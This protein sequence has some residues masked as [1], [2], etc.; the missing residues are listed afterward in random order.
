MS[1]LG[2]KQTSADV[3]VMSA[4]SQKPTLIEQVGMSAVPEA[5]ILRSGTI[6]GYLALGCIL[7]SDLKS[8]RNRVPHH[9]GA[10]EP[11]LWVGQDVQAA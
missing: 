8:S 2:Q 9:S 6:A 4:L 7:R 1:A 3:R 11:V 5:D 10:E